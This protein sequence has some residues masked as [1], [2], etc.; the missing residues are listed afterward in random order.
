MLAHALAAGDVAAARAMAERCLRAAITAGSPSE[1]GAAVDALALV[2]PE[3]GAALLYLALEGALDIRSK[4]AAALAELAPR[5]AM[6]RLRTAYSSAD[7]HS[8]TK[9]DFAAALYRL[10]ERDRAVRAALVAVLDDPSQQRVAAVALAMAGDSTA[11]P[12]LTVLLDTRLSPEARRQITAALARLGGWPSRAWL[13]SELAH[14]DAARRVGAAEL[15][16]RTGDPDGADHLARQAADPEFARCGDAALALARLGDRRALDW[17]Q[18]GMR[19]LDAADR[20]QALAILGLLGT[21]AAHAPALATLATD[22]DLGVRM[23]VEAVSL[24]L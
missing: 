24:G 21:A 8:R 10:G 14:P 13:D 2:R 15:L 4:A 1:R 6:P 12:A 22:P 16:A 18:A 11:R 9:L 7:P 17:T 19:S 5:D 20:R 23:T 3:A